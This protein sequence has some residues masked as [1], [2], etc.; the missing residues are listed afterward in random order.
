MG[1]GFF[2]MGRFSGDL[3]LRIGR[4]FPMT[5]TVPDRQNIFIAA[6]IIRWKRGDEYEVETLVADD[7]TLGQVRDYIKQQFFPHQSA[8]PQLVGDPGE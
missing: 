2:A 4:S 1:E 8:Q 5:V 6:G 3:A 7:S